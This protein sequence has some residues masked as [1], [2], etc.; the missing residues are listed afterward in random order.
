MYTYDLSQ[1]ILFFFLYSFVGWIWEC[2]YVSVKKHRWVNRGFMHGPFLPLYGSGALVILVS[3]MP[4][5]DNLAL[6]FLMGMAGATLLEYLTGMTMERLFRVKYWDYSN[7]KFNVKGYICPAASLCWGCFSVL[8]VRFIH[9]PVEEMILGLPRAVSEGTAFVLTAVAAVDFT[10]SFNEAMD[11]KEILTQLEE[12][13]NQIYRIQEK[14]KATSEEMQEKVRTVSAEMMEDYR[15]FTEKRAVEKQ[16]RKEAF[17]EQIQSRRIEKRK[18]LAELSAKVE[19]LLKEELPSRV[20]GLLSRE[21]QEELAEIRRTIM[22]ELQKMASRT[23]KNYIRAARHLRRNP[24]AVSERF[25]EV[26]EELRK[27]MD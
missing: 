22:R 15:E 8:M 20:G 5:R 21:Q 2:C 3:T 19:I 11:M 27:Y 26:L 4:V 24:T 12:S 17:L 1:W 13:R 16:S 6:V 25:K 7:Q 14:L 18:Q 10:Q 9:V 23:D